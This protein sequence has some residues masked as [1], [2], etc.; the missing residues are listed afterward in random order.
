VLVE[1]SPVAGAFAPHPAPSNIRQ[2]ASTLD[3][4]IFIV[5]LLNGH[6]D[7]RDS[8]ESGDRNVRGARVK[9]R[10]GAA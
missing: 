7:R 5:A 8:D 10:E 2:P 4:V 9:N 3:V 1:P 6:G